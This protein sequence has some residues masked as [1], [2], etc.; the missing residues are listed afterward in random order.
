M[1]DPFCFTE[2]KFQEECAVIGVI[3]HPEAANYCYLGLYAMQ[4]RGQEG[5]GIVSTNG[6]KMYA[7]RQMGLVADV[8][9]AETLQSLKG[10]CAVGHNR[11]ATFGGKD[12]RNLQP[13]IASFSDNSFAVGHNGNLVNASEVKIELEKN[14]SIFTTS[15][16]TEV[17][18]HLIARQDPKLTLV[19]KLRACL[20][21]VKGAYSLVVQSLDRLIAVRDP[22]G[23]RPLSLGRIGSAYVV[24]SE[25]CAFDLVGAEFVRDIQ[26]GE[27]LEITREGVLNSV[28]LPAVSS[29]FCVFEYVY[30]A[31]PDST[32][33]GRNVYSVR[34]RLG[35]ELAK[36]QP[37]D[38]DLVIPVPDSG[39]PA[40]LGYA[41]QIGVP[42]EFGLIRNHYIGRTFIEPKQSIR[43]FG[44]KVKLNPS[45]AILVGKKVAVVDDSI[46]RGTTCQKL[47]KML[48]G[49]GAAEVHF[50]I[51]SPP[52]VGPCHYGI[53]TPSRK[54][55]VAAENSIE[56]IR[57]FIGADSLG[58]LSMEGMYRA[59]EGKREQYCD[60][61]FSNDYR[62]GVPKGKRG[63]ETVSQNHP[64]SN[65]R[66]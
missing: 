51:S 35:A 13:L 11:Y 27:I 18:L 56:Q 32:I 54:E 53:D 12:W 39:V 16:D 42:M 49:A 60:A 37:S 2:D 15:T 20:G 22:A 33:D 1:K 3:G 19:E 4:H 14:G 47:V 61:C 41:Q 63:T 5:S 36:E 31:R 7:H 58:Y 28:F 62:L 21:S 43:D 9:D 59:V 26:P 34:K 52:T 64:G 57:Q 38:V 8:F 24:A 23:V 40:A 66:N 46:V 44:V 65:G 45:P 25:T 6:K 48:R 30:F 17:F 50:R 10:D 55:L 29:A